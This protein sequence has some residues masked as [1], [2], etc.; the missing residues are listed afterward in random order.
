MFQGASTVKLVAAISAVTLGIFLPFQVLA[1]PIALKSE[2]FVERMVTKPDGSEETTLK[3]ADRVIP[4][5]KLRIVI[6]FTNSG[7]ESATDFVITNPVPG[8]IRYIESAGAVD[9]VVSVDG[10]RFDALERLVV[11]EADGSTR[12]AR[13]SDVTHIRWAFADPIP[14]GTAANVFYRGELR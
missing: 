12:A 2:I 11:T 4:G 9:A 13:A 8:S 7:P 6:S 10:E 1:A 5:D 3:P 14:A